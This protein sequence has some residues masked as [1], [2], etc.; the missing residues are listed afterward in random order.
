MPGANKIDKRDNAM[1]TIDELTIACN[2]INDS[3]QRVVCNSKTA[4]IIKTSSFG[5]RSEIVVNDYVRDNECLI[6]SGR[7]AF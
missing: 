3:Q 6:Y 5:C 1:M 7:N 4:E 2:L